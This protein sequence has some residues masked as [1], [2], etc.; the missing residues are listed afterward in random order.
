[1]RRHPVIHLVRGC[2]AFAGALV[3]YV[4]LHP[5][6]WPPPSIERRGQRQKVLERVQSAGGWEAVRKGCEA[7]AT[8]YPGGLTWF[9]PHCNAWVYPNPQTAPHRNYVTIFDYGSLPSAVAALNP[10][11]IRYD[12]PR[13]LRDAKDE[14]QVAVVCITIFGRHS[15]GGHS[16]PDYGLEIPCGP[17]AE[18]YEPRPGRGVTPGNGYTSFRKLADGVFEVY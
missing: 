8:N 11:E 1:M 6:L 4:A 14:P 7:L 18:N 13:L 12:P 17:G 15:S 10:K 2:F 16:T 3:I 5:A 9:P